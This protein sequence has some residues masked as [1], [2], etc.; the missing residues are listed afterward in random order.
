MVLSC[1]VGSLHRKVFILLLSLL[2]FLLCNR[3]SISTAQS[4]RQQRDV[5]GVHHHHQFHPK[6]HN[7]S[8]EPIS[9]H[10]AHANIWTALNPHNRIVAFYNLYIAKPQYYPN[11]VEEQLELMKMTGL[12]DR[13][14]AV[15]YVA[16]GN[17]VD[18][19]PQ[20]ILKT[21]R[22]TNTKGQPKFVEV[23][24]TLK[25]VDETLTL[26]YLYDFC[27]HNPDSKVLYFHDKGSYNHRGENV[28]FRH[29]L[30]CYVLN[31][32]CID[33]LNEGFDTCGWRMSPLPNPHYSGN[34]WWARCEYVNKL[35]H[36]AIYS[37]NTT[38]HDL[39]LSLPHDI[40]SYGRYFPESWIG[41]YPTI[42]PADCMDHTIDTSFLCCYDLSDISAKQCPNHAK[43]FI[44][45]IDNMKRVV[46]DKLKPDIKKKLLLQ[47]QRRDNDTN[48]LLLQIGSRCK[49][50]DVFTNGQYYSKLFI[51]KRGHTE[52]SMHHSNFVDA[53][54]KRSQIWYGQDPTTVLKAID[55]LE[56][57]PTL[58][59]RAMIV[60]P[61]RRNTLYLYVNG[62]LHQP[63]TVQYRRYSGTK[64]DRVQEIPMYS[65]MI[66]R[67]KAYLKQK[68]STNTIYE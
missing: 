32:Q 2:Y 44:P 42:N 3:I 49:A 30:D 47:Y 34:Y 1:C 48:T 36:P 45:N 23:H 50:A 41:S 28:F 7:H 64:H 15:Y 5:P 66:E 18:T 16:I 59:D 8:E 63:G 46:Y 55:Q 14:D 12:L 56:I 11:I 65:F 4:P 39:T 27:Q 38:F 17:L 37:Y 62:S 68:D 40:A 6:S 9:K 24:N 67:L 13:L 25:S 61:F 51:E 20:H 33:A 35:V 19:M 21:L 58:P 54:K 22:Q 52:L 31:P 43:H 29:F 26:S 53:L 60:D 57:L 10:D